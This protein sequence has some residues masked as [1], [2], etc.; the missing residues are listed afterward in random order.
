MMM[1]LWQRIRLDLYHGSFMLKSNAHG[2]MF[3]ARCNVELF[4]DT[5]GR[6]MP[7]NFQLRHAVSRVW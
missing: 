6:E 3:S 5:S 2:E 7:R 1:A 4:A